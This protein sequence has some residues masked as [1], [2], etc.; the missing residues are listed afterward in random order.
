MSDFGKCVGVSNV[1]TMPEKHLERAAKENQCLV[2]ELC[3]PGDCLGGDKSNCLNPKLTRWI[4]PGIEGNAERYHNWIHHSCVNSWKC[5][6]KTLE[7][8]TSLINSSHI[9]LNIDPLN[10]CD[11][12]QKANYCVTQQGWTVLPITGYGGA[13]KMIQVPCLSSDKESICFDEEEGHDI[14]LHLGDETVTKNTVYKFVSDVYIKHS[15]EP[16][17]LP[18]LA[19]SEDLEHV[20]RILQYENLQ[21]LYNTQKL[22]NRIEELEKTISSMLMLMYGVTKSPLEAR[23]NITE[24]VIISNGTH[25]MLKS[26]KSVENVLKK[27]NLSVD[28]GTRSFALFG[29]SQL[30]ENSFSEFDFQVNQ[31]SQQQIESLSKKSINAEDIEIQ[32]IGFWEGFNGFVLAPMV[33]M[34]HKLTL[35]LCILNTWMIF[36]KLR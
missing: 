2:G 35:P 5:E 9:R 6:T 1:I 19:S 21:S 20:Y 17:F 29:K 14:V 15:E 32:P 27:G 31:F 7:V 3:R 28:S 34:L 30:S 4:D 22:I 33:A 24:R 23:L 8:V 18:G 11:M 36:S 16:S 10:Y 26:C 13:E 12:D 25:V